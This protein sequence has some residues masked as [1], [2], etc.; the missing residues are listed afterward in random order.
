MKLSADALIEACDDASHAA[1]ITITTALEPLAG[2]FAPVKPPIYPGASSGDGP[3]YQKDTRWFGEGADARTVEAVVIDNVPSEANRL[4]A[5]LE[6]LR[7]DAGLPAIEVDLAAAA[8][9]PP[10][11]P[12]RLSIFRFPHRSAD[13]YLRDASLDGT[14]FPKTDTGVAILSATADSPAALFEWAPQSLLYG[15]WQSH[16]GKKGSQAKLARS[17]VSEIVGYEPAATDTTVLGVKGDPAN[18]PNDI[19]VDA[20]EDDGREWSIAASGKGKKLS[21]VGHGQVPL[22]GSTPAPISFRSIEQRSTVSFASLRRV[23][24]PAPAEGRAL[25]AAM[26]LLAHVAAFGRPFSLRSG[27]DLR[28]VSTSWTWLGATADEAIDAPTL[29]EA[30]ALFRS[31]VAAAE[32]AGLPVG[33]KWASEPLVLVPNAEL[34]KVLAQTFP[35]LD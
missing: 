25:L 7:S 28:P 11:V 12:G 20:N 22:G 6:G 8:T 18:L 35:T 26:G 4:E 15:F 29:D 14:N 23:N 17:W 21:E 5:A 9:L 3:Q 33:S 34:T 13:A 31:V 24:G 2:L 30:A 16:L 32:A 27:C 10:H 19:P 1:G